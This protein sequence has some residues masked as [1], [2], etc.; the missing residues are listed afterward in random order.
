MGHLGDQHL[1]KVFLRI[2]SRGA[3]EQEEGESLGIKKS[4]HTSSL[5][6]F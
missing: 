5:P 2:A 3:N 4:K 6:F 1:C